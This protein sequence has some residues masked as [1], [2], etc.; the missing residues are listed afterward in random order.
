MEYEITE[1]VSGVLS[2]INSFDGGIDLKTTVGVHKLYA[3]ANATLFQ[4]KR[5]GGVTDITIDNI[6]IKRLNGDDTPRID[7]TDGGCPVL[8]TEPQSTN[9]ITHSSDFSASSWV[10]LTDITI[11]PNTTDVLS[12]SGLND[13]NKVVSADSTRGFY[14]TGL[15]GTEAAT[16]SIY[17]KGSVGG[18]TLTLKDGSGNGGVNAF[19]LTTDWVRYELKTTN[20]GG[21]YQ[22]LFVADISVGTI[23]AW[24]AQYE[25]LPYATSLHPNIRSSSYKVTRFCIRS[26]NI[27]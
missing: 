20:D 22:G 2:V 18:E 3:V 7:Y 15:S 11:T 9:F 27:K 21:T 26:G 23:Y 5:G 1:S 19:T 17:L 16:R 6:K 13:A 10:A 12:P 25:Q 24:G 4:V 8:L 14:Y